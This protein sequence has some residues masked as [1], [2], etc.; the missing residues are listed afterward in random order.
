MG[1][2][3]LHCEHF[4]QCLLF[5]TTVCFVALIA[6]IFHNNY[7]KRKISR[8]EVRRIEVHFDNFKSACCFVSYFG[9]IVNLIVCCFG[10]NPE[11]YS[12][13]HI[14]YAFT[15]W[16]MLVF[17]SRALKFLVMDIEMHKKHLKNVI[18]C[19]IAGIIILPLLTKHIRTWNEI[20]AILISQLICMPSSW[21]IADYLTIRDGGLEF[22]EIEVVLDVSD[23]ESDNSNSTDSDSS[24][25][26]IDFSETYQSTGSL[27][28]VCYRTYSNSN[29]RKIPLMLKNCGHTICEGCAGR[30]LKANYNSYLPC[31]FCRKKTRVD[32]VTKL[33]KNYGML[34]MLN[35]MKRMESFNHSILSDNPKLERRNSFS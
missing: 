19:Q 3:E 1:I 23:F 14:I 6:M 15:N 16:L 24:E 13:C 31:P 20:S 10:T 30:I 12:T 32:S 5:T 28:G 17:V 9:V 11:I 26:D 8:G 2:L 25:S 7:I 21:S 27:C 4:H 22:R 18:L 33:P 35:D 29:S 34:Q